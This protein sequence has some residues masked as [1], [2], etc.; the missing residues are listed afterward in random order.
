MDKTTTW[1]VKGASVIVIIFGIS[2]FAQPYIQRFKE[3]LYF[4]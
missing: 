4:R 1:L 3:Y 2:Y